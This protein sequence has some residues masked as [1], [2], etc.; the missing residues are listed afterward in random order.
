[1]QGHCQQPSYLSI[2]HRRRKFAEAARGAREAARDTQNAADLAD[3]DAPGLFAFINSSLGD[4]SAAAA[5]HRRVHADERRGGGGAASLDEAAGRYF[6]NGAA[7]KA[8]AAPKPP[9]RQALA[10][11]Q[12]PLHRA[13]APCD[14]ADNTLACSAASVGGLRF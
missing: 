13:Q 14:T 10:A 2:C 11:Q 3:P 7:A 1:M 9:D 12:V 6:G 5:V 8:K 4:G